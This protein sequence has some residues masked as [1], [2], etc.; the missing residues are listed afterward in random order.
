MATIKKISSNL[1]FAYEGEEAAKLYT[2][3]F[4]NSSI[5]RKSYYGKESFETHGM[6]EGTAMTVEFM[7]EDQSFF[8]LIGGPHFKFN[9]AV[10]FIISC[11]SQEEIDYYWDKLSEG[12][13][14]K[15]QICGWLKDKFGL[16]WQVVPTI[17]T[18]M[19]SNSDPVSVANVKRVMLQMK[20]R[21]LQL[22]RKPLTI[23]PWNSI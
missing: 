20:K 15:A 8:T 22:S 9:E 17:L 5:G 11:G 13:D 19:I 21:I 7:L 18:D 3:L 4:K 10:S 1:L 14:P 6:K 16:S 12:G 23:E 2:S